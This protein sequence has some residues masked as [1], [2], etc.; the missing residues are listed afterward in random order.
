MARALA[1]PPRPGPLRAAWY[2][3]CDAADI[4]QMLVLSLLTG[5]AATAAACALASL[6]LWAARAA[7]EAVARHPLA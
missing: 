7:R 4:G 1:S 2:L 6:A 3:L 5:G